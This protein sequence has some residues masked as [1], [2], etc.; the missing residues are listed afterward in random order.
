[1]QYYLQTVFI[2]L[3]RIFE[4]NITSSWEKNSLSGPFEFW[5]RT[6]LKEGVWTPL[7]TSSPALCLCSYLI[8]LES[9]TEAS[10]QGEEGWEKGFVNIFSNALIEIGFKLLTGPWWQNQVPGRKCFCIANVI[11]C[12]LMRHSKIATRYVFSWALFFRLS[13]SLFQNPLRLVFL[14][15]TTVR[16]CC[17]LS[18]SASLCG[19]LYSLHAQIA[20]DGAEILIAQYIWGN[21]RLICCEL[22][23]ITQLNGALP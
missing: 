20:P 4:A 23:F 1:M 18:C 22:S 7:S 2:F 19:K 16:S 11:F 12:L 21:K 13:L 3:G 14:D 9:N 5:S 6:R 8:A 15:W 10:N 17:L